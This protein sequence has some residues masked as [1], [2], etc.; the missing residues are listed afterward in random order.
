MFKVFENNNRCMKFKKFLFP[1]LPI[2]I[3]S[4][5][6][7]IS[8]LAI[9]MSLRFVLQFTSFYVP[10][11]SFS[12]SVSWTPLIIIGWIYGPIFG[13]T[14][15]FITDS[16][17]TLL[18]GS[19]WFWLYAIQEPMIGLIAA[20]FGYICRY[21]TSKSQTKKTYID[22]IFFEIITIAFSLTCIFVLLIQTKS[23]NSFENKSKLEAFFLDNSIWIISSSV[24]FF[25]IFI[26]SIALIF[27]FK[28]KKNFRVVI[29]TI[30]LVCTLSI[31]MSFILGPISA[32]EYYKFIH[33]GQSSPSWLKLGAIFYL[34]PR[35]FKESI[36]A[37]I[38]IFILL[39]VMPLANNYVNNVVLSK[40]LK[41]NI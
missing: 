3:F 2:K 25:F 31:L 27:Y 18:S 8:M 19:T 38:Q 15:G 24:A 41:W 30:T 32:N 28:F 29:W 17:G 7:C 23:G 6:N 4:S 34:V 39:S 22:L 11:F 14:V 26:Q 9:L 37:P 36:K 20:I 12:I 40:Q 33:N 13:I 10:V 16:I 35:V 1:L 5:T 21:A